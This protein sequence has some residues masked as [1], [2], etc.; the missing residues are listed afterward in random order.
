MKKLLVATAVIVSA[1]GM[2]GVSYGTASAHSYDGYASQDQAYAEHWQGGGYYEHD[3]VATGTVVE[4]LANDDRFTTLVAAVK[5]ANLVDALN[6]PGEKTVFAPTN[7]A[8]EKLPA[9]TVESL[10][11]NPEALSSVLLNHVVAGNIDADTAN[12]VG[13]ADTLSGNK[14]NI[15]Y[16]DDGYLYVNDSRIVVQDVWT[17][18]GVIHVIDAVLVP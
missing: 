17:S 14:L 18:N 13:E 11:A 12:Y 4:T 7:S 5:A 2:A 6:A 15:G 9:G 8:F 3:V 1:V 16:G 10:L